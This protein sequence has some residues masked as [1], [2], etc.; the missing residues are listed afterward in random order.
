MVLSTPVC[1]NLRQI[2]SFPQGTGETYKKIWNNHLVML[3]HHKKHDLRLAL[4]IP[5]IQS[6]PKP[7]T[8]CQSLDVI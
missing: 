2:G 5:Q 1:K 4:A 8:D 3:F 6:L 7:I